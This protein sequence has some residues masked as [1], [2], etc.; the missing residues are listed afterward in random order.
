MQ[1]GLG[2]ELCVR[3]SQVG[4]R[5]LEAS[6]APGVLSVLTNDATI[7]AQATKD[8]APR[9]RHHGTSEV[10]ETEEGGK[11]FEERV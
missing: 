5:T 1:L 11:K 3:K 10:E 6:F 4:S 8:V 7:S 9:A 2:P